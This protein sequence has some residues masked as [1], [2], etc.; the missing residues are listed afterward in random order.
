MPPRKTRSAPRGAPKSGSPV[1]ARV[2][3]DVDAVAAL[4]LPVGAPDA[5]CPAAPPPVVVG[6]LTLAPELGALPVVGAPV[7]PELTVVLV[8]LGAPVV[9]P[10]E[11]VLP[12]WVLVALGA[13]VVLP[14]EPV[15]PTWVLVALGPPVVLPPE[16]DEPWLADVALGPPAVLPPE[17]V[18]P[19]LADVALGAPVVLPPEPVEPWLALVALGAPVVLPPEPVLLMLLALLVDEVDFADGA[20]VLSPSWPVAFVLS[21]PLP[22]LCR[23]PFESELPSPVSLCWPVAELAPAD[24]P[25]LPLA[26]P[27]PLAVVPPP[28]L[29]VSPPLAVVVPPPLALAVLSPL[30]WDVPPPE[31][32][33]LPSPPLDFCSD[34]VWA[35]PLSPLEGAASWLAAAPPVLPWSFPS[36]SPLPPPPPIS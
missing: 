27:P 13:P 24:A 15:L 36:P 17:P 30:D 19:W 35:L 14:V 4:T 12:T 25:P 22:P 11:P 9:L 2:T 5:V 28:A 26:E 31:A 29:A 1:T 16:P 6:A 20:E 23:S 8:A 10:V 32:L 34:D 7:D 18:E 3:P 21:S 33:A